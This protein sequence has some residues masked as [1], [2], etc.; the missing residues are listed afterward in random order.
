M[1]INFAD[2]KLVKKYGSWVK[3]QVA[4]YD[5][6]FETG[7]ELCAEH[8]REQSVAAEILLDGAWADGNPIYEK[9]IAAIENCL[10][11]PVDAWTEFVKI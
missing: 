11:S 9:T 8:F 2:E 3:V 7:S 5:F 4:F 1:S 6:L 10:D